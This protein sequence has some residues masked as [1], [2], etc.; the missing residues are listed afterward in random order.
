MD[1]KKITNRLLIFGFTVAPFLFALSGLLIWKHFA[2]HDDL[3]YLFLYSNLFAVG[4]GFICIVK[5]PETRA[6]GWF[7]AALYPI[8][9][10]LL[11]WFFS[12]ITAIVLGAP[13]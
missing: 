4:I 8:L 7:F 11:V 2:W 6:L 3:S 9:C 10:F 12:V 13:K 1:A 5:H